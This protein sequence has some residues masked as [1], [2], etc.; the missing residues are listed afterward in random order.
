MT[1]D[2]WNDCTNPAAMLTF[3]RS[4][5]SASDRKLRLFAVACC[6]RVWPLLTDERARKAVEFADGLVG[7][8][9]LAA[10]AFEVRTALSDPASP[11]PLQAAAGAIWLDA[12]AASHY[13]AFATAR[14]SNGIRFPLLCEARDVEWLGQAAMLCDLFGTL[15]F[16]DIDMGP[17]LLTWRDGTLPKLARAIYEERRFGDLPVLADALEEAGCDNPDMVRHCRQQEAVHVRGCWLLDLLM[18]RA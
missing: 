7:E 15:P 18:G 5:G 4:T 1:G 11:G 6:R 14:T 8:P 10:A 3:L 13:A 2:E 17:S 9:A 12:F 16:R